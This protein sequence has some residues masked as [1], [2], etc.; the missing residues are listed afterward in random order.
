MFG[1]VFLLS[2]VPKAAVPLVAGTPRWLCLPVATLAVAALAVRLP[3]ITSGRLDHLGVGY[4]PLLVVLPAYSLAG[5]KT[6]VEYL[7]TW[8]GEWYSVAKG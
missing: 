7:L 4:L 2:L 1:N 3:D 5:I 6:V 8:D